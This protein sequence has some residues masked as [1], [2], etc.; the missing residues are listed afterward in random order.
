MNHTSS[1]LNPQ[2]SFENFVVGPCN[3]FAQSAAKGVAQNPAEIYNPLFLHGGVGL[4]KTHLMQAIGHAIRSDR[5]SNKR[6]EYLTTETFTNQLVAAIKK[7]STAEFRDKYRGIDVLL[8]DD[9]HFIARKNATQ[10][11]FFHT[12]NAL[13][14]KKK[15]IVIC[16]DRPPKE[17]PTLED[18]LISRFEWGL[19]AAIQPPDYDTRVAILTRKARACKSPIPTE[20]IRLIATHIR[21][22]IRELEGALT[23]LIATASLNRQPITVETAADILK[24]EIARTSAGEITVQ[25]IILAT[26]RSFGLRKGDLTSQRRSRAITHPRQIAMYLCRELTTDSLS[27]IARPFNKKDH[28]TIL[29]AHRK[30]ASLINSD[31]TQAASIRRL[32]EELESPATLAD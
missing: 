10:E 4:G 13:H 26:E 6:V 17:I 7:R 2:Y 27:H 21:S 32:R 20:A 9:I 23:R 12:F 15:Q 24:D 14:D 30:I 22:N 28:T 3:L 5:R 8:V 31:P 29:H 25:K 18:R 16:S 1:G 19:V 11:E